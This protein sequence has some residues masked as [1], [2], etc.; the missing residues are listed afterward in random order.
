MR[1][2]SYARIVVLG[3]SFT[4]A[5]DLHVCPNPDRHFDNLVSQ[6]FPAGDSESVVVCIYTGGVTCTYLVSA[7]QRRAFG[8]EAVYIT[9][10]YVERENL[11]G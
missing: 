2:G 11:P 8:N 9:W 1:L 10:T 6:S 4:S 5:L 7:V 3:A